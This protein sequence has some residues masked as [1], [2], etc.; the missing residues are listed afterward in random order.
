MFV[1]IKTIQVKEGFADAVVS[2]F[3]QPGAVEKAEGFVD[4]SVLVKRTRKGDEEIAVIIRWESEEAWK[5]W[6]RSEPHLEGH[7]R[8]REQGKPEFILGSS[9]ATYDLKVHK[10]P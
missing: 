3:S 9:H 4:L 2:R 10:L 1:E 8:S 7:R 6:E 5:G